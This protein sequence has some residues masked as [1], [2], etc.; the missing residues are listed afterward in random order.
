[1]LPMPHMSTS[2][3]FKTKRLVIFDEIMQLMQKV[4]KKIFRKDLK[5]IS[6][7]Y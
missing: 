1:M 3:L 2:L 5:N 4:S 7:L 6:S